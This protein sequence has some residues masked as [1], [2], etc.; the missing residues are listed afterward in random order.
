MSRPVV[1]SFDGSPPAAA[2]LTVAAGELPGRHLLI[3]SVWEP[4]FTTA[5]LTPTDASGLSFTA[6]DPNQVVAVD[7]LQRDHATQIA[8][9]GVALA[10]RLGATAEAVPA[11]DEA[12]VSETLCSIADHHDAALIVVGSR[13]LGAVKA[14]LLGSTTRRLLHDARRPVLVVRDG[15][16]E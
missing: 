10:E 6:P 11:R 7:R 5:M 3:V 15:D 8:E 9:A 2:A 4:G 1:V 12:S 16:G 13:G 14:R